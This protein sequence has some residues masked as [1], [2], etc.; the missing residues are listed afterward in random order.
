[1]RLWGGNCVP[2]ASRS[3]LVRAP[4]THSVYG[5]A[6]SCT[7]VALRS[8]RSPEASSTMPDG[9]LEGVGASAAKPSD[10]DGD[11][12]AVWVVGG[13]WVVGGAVA[14]VRVRRLALL[15]R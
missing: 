13:C 2:H 11:G 4:S 9:R 3:R 15:E 6:A 5:S 7:G 12:D 1:M 14:R 10:G 8:T